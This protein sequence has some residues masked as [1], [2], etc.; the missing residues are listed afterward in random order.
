MKSRN[1]G[2]LLMLLAT[3]DYA[4]MNGLL[5]EAETT[6]S[7]GTVLFYRFLFS[8][9]ILL[10]IILFKKS[11]SIKP[12]NIKLLLLRGMSGFVTTL[13]LVYALRSLPSATVILLSDTAPLF[14]PLIL[15]L[16]YKNKI[17]VLQVASICIGFTGV[18]FILHPGAHSL[19]SL[20]SLIG[21]CSGFLLAIGVVLMRR[22]SKTDSSI[23]ITAY[24]CLVSAICSIVFFKVRIHGFTT[25]DY[26]LFVGIGLAATIYQVSIAKALA[27]LPASTVSPLLYMAVVFGSVGDYV[28]WHVTPEWF[29]FV[30]FALILM[31]AGFNFYN[32]YRLRYSGSVP[33]SSMSK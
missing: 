29:T 1:M 9:L 10:P 25:D 27:Y 5:K 23:S 24:Y 12:K 2:F 32:T 31:S 26:L 14:V 18:L 33:S 22:L 6:L 7:D 30:G 20:S 4:I 21:L 17:T 3:L 28:F 8:L 19:G 16:I 11:V 15:F 13:C